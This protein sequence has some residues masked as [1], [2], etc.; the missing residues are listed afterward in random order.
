MFGSTVLE[1]A[2]G[3][4][5]VFLLLSLVA[6]A[7]QEAV[8]TILK[9]R[10]VQLERGIRELLNDK[11]GTGLATALYNHPLIYSLYRGTYRS[12]GWRG[13][14][15][16]WRAA[17]PSYIPSRSF[18]VALLDI[19][20]RGENAVK[21]ETATADVP[22]LTFEGVRSSV[23]KIQNPPVQRA[24][25]SA[26]DMAEGDLQRARLNIQSWFDGTMD[27]VSGWFKRNTQRF[28][29]VVGFG[30]AILA[31]ADSVALARYL[32]QDSAAREALAAQVTATRETIQNE[33]PSALLARL[34]SLP[35]GA[36]EVTFI[37]PWKTDHDWEDFWSPLFGW[38]ITA[39]AISLGAPFWFDLLNKIMVIR[40]TV[41]P[42]EKSP[43]EASE[44]RQPRKS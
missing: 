39:L 13:L 31:N 22:G 16:V 1:V 6:T 14:P 18:A 21:A 27:R 24:L 36:A 5:F 2:V 33:K 37:L 17:L 7:I 3:L 15:L 28:L 38:S 35:L 30:L 29:L 41:K 32:Y 10:S 19:V 4:L 40:S 34:D 11:E 42:R 44:D 8:Q 43:E 26:L 20:A 9:S 12:P 25:L 23:Q